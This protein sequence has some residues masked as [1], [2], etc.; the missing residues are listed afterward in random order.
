MD[1]VSQKRRGVNLAL[2][3]QPGELS[4]IMR[5]FPQCGPKPSGHELVC[6][7]AAEEQREFVEGAATKLIHRLGLEVLEALADILTAK[8]RIGVLRVGQEAFRPLELPE[9][10]G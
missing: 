7:I 9:G 8:F 10:R 3:R 6:G 4:K 2:V 5:P 1:A